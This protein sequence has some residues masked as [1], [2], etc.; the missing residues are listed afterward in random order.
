MV[1]VFTFFRVMQ[2]RLVVFVLPLVRR[3]VRPASKW[4]L[5]LVW[6]LLWRPQLIQAQL[7]KAQVIEVLRDGGLYL[8]QAVIDRR[9]RAQGAYN[10]L[11]A[12]WENYQTP[13]RT[14]QTSLALLEAYRVSPNP[15]FL[16]QAKESGQWWVRQRI[17]DQPELL[18]LIDATQREGIGDVLGFSAV[19]LGTGA[20]F[21]LTDQ[22]GDSIYAETAL[23]AGEWLWRNT[24]DPVTG[25]CYNYLNP[26]TGLVV[27]DRTPYEPQ[28]LDP[29]LN[30]VSRP[31]PEGNMWAEMFRYTGDS[32]YWAAHLQSCRTL[33]RVQNPQGLWMSYAPNDEAT[34]RIDLWLNLWYADALI[35]A[36]ALSGDAAF[37]DGAARTVETYLKLQGR[38]GS[39]YADSYRD[40]QAER[41]SAR[42][43][44]VA[45]LGLV[46]LRLEAAG[47]SGYAP[48]IH[49]CAAWLYYNR[50]AIIHADPNLRGAIIDLRQ[51]IRR[52]QLEVAN[53]DL[54][55]IFGVRFMATYHD[56]LSGR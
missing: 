12:R 37:L 48:Y 18:G 39:L 11:K 50:Y 20:L 49:Q 1:R 28:N 38:D 46:M 52:N 44:A 8:T 54:G 6:G 43:S 34:G 23:A 2:D 26:R 3:L 14:A 51:R 47:R 4:L 33:L 31:H 55:T 32:T 45:M 56:Y 22:T 42:G 29:G 5:V 40:G 25:I 21:A 15:K 27:T 9:G 17:L 30:L 13:W 41:R 19:A 35:E 7:T 10:L 36:H 24:C 53:L 16:F